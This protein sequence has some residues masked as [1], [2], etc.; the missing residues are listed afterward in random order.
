MRMQARGNAARRGERGSAMNNS[1]FGFSAVYIVSRAK[2]RLTKDE[3]QPGS[4]D[5]IGG[6]GEI[7]ELLG[8]RAYESTVRQSDRE[9]LFVLHVPAGSRMG[10]GLSR[11]SAESAWRVWKNKIP[12]RTRLPKGPGGKTAL[13]AAS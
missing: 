6:F 1:P 3:K 8:A 12:A 5:E 10:R 11:Q 7:G 2:R 13:I 4:D 9:P